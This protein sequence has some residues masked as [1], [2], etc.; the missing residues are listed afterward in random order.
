MDEIPSNLS[1]IRQYLDVFANLSELHKC[2][3]NLY[4]AILHTLDAILPEYQ[5]HVA[6]ERQLLLQLFTE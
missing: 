5:K 2:N 3:A 1:K 6:H 4:L